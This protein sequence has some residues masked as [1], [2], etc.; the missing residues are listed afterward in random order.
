MVDL[1]E[2]AEIQESFD[3][4][5]INAVNGQSEL[6][7][8]NSMN[9][10]LHSSDNDRV[11]SDEML[12]LL[13]V[14]ITTIIVLV[15]LTICISACICICLN[16]RRNLKRQNKKDHLL[17]PEQ[18]EKITHTRSSLTNPVTKN[19]TLTI[20]SNSKQDLDKTILP[21]S[22]QKSASNLIHGNAPIKSYYYDTFDDIPFIDESRPTSY[23]DITRV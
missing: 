14:A 1:S 18:S 16:K 2:K 21:S 4:Q 17:L 6:V 19:I 11:V 23:I 7:N 10:T 20:L 22:I 13:L 12:K 9:D 8:N 3:F 5:Y 15:C